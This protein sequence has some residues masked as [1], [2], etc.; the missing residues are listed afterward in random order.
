M[1][2]NIKQREELKK[3]VEE[4]KIKSVNSSNTHDLV[5]GSL[6]MPYTIEVSKINYFLRIQQIQMLVNSP[7]LIPILM[8]F[9]KSKLNLLEVRIS[10]M[11]PDII[12]VT[13]ILPRNTRSKY[14]IDTY[15]LKGYNIITY[16]FLKQGICIYANPNLNMILKHGFGVK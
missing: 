16:N 2:R 5:R 8:S 10:L 12:R 15:Q 14:S 1:D 11:S 7:Y 4:A 3:L 13:E 6:F 9:N